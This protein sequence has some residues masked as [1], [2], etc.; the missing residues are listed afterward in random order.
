MKEQED[1]PEAA[2]TQ[3]ETMQVQFAIAKGADAS[4]GAIEI[5]K[6]PWFV[7]A[8]N[9]TKFQE[10]RIF[11]YLDCCKFNIGQVIDKAQE[12]MRKRAA[13]LPQG[14]KPNGGGSGYVQGIVDK[15]RR[16]H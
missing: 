1:K 2:Q 5:N 6:E 11:Q 8:I 14:G 4:C 3:P 16:H 15:L 7:I 10:N 13:F 9:L 12:E